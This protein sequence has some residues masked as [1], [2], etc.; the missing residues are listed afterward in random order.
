MFWVWDLFSAIVLKSKIIYKRK[1]SL[2][3]LGENSYEKKGV[4]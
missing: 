2:E 1:W 4:L 3:Y